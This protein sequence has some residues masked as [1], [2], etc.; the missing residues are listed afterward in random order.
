M[1]EGPNDKGKNEICQ[2]SVPSKFVGFPLKITFVLPGVPAPIGGF[3][4][5]YEYANHLSARGH[6]VTIVH[7]RAHRHADPPANVWQGIRRK[8]GYFLR[9]FFTPTVHWMP[10]A[11]KVHMRMTPD[12]SAASVDDGDVVVATAWQTS[13]YVA[14]YP[15]SKGRKYYLV[16]DFDHWFGPQDLVEASWKF[17]MK[18]VAISTFIYEK[19]VAVTADPKNVIMIPCGVAHER[20]R[21]F[22]DLAKRSTIAMMYSPG[23]YKAAEDGV[24]AL[25]ICKKKYPDIQAVVYGR[26]RRPRGLP[27][28]V[29]YRSQI[30]EEELVQVYNQSKIFLCSSLAEG[31]ALPPAEAMACGCAV[32]STRCGGNGEYAEH[33]V[34]ALLSP[35][36]QPGA[37]AENVL[38]LLED[39]E[40]RVQLAQAGHRRIQ[41]FTWERSADLL[42]K[43]FLK[44]G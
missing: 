27:S 1:R 16:M 31:F 25:E 15:A 2:S 29:E 9:K 8:G 14:G 41:R 36:G 7:P 28:W 32:V 37:L 23:P 10:M 17:P 13:D 22:N 4:T 19:V 26:T 24:R 43:Y 11:P 39:D 30:A 12:L 20:F 21:L 38:K 33:G 3:R 42:E 18:K 5:V 6:E 44:D 34:T 35:P 40:L